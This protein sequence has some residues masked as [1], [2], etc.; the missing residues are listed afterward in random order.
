MSRNINDNL[1]LEKSKSYKKKIK[2]LLNK[3]MFQVIQ[4]Y[5]LMVRGSFKE[6][7]I[8]FLEICVFFF[9]VWAEFKS[10]LIFFNDFDIGLFILL[11]LFKKNSLLVIRLALSRGQLF[12]KTY[13]RIEFNWIIY[14][15]QH[16]KAFINY[17]NYLFSIKISFM[18][19]LWFD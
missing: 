3:I 2:I 4:V 12:A 5:V 8:S 16:K 18:V 19:V 11:F 9:K 6:G 14:N 10:I 7:Y 15:D 17:L 1:K 13:L